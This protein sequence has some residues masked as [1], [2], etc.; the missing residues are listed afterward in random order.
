MLKKAAA[1]NTFKE[2]YEKLSQRLKANVE[3]VERLLKA[4]AV[5]AFS[6][7]PPPSRICLCRPLQSSR[8][9]PSLL[10]LSSPALS[11]SSS[12]S[13]LYVSILICFCYLFIFP[14]NIVSPSQLKTPQR[15][16]ISM[17][18]IFISDFFY[19]KIQE[20]TS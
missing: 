10:W 4:T 1:Q 2:Q 7:V 5:P 15:L 3:D 20:K 14:R 9:V 8:R 6:A 12:D 16:L 13:E 18:F 17:R 19:S 11:I